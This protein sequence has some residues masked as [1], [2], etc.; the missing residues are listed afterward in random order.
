MLFLISRLG[1]DRY[2]IEVVEI[3]PLVDSEHTPHAR[4]DVAG[5]FG[6]RDTIASFDRARPTGAGNASAELHE[7]LL[8]RSNSSGKPSRNTSTEQ[9]NFA[10]GKCW[11]SRWLN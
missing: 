8:A 4:F 5:V 11:N 10:I 2:A 6:C 7:D 1:V 3:L 9:N